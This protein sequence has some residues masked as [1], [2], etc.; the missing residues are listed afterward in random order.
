M[1][2]EDNL[3]QQ[4]IK[5]VC[6]NLAEFL[7]GKN[8]AYGNSALEPMRVFSSA[9]TQEQLF[10]RIDD[11]LSRIMRGKEYPGDDTI[12]DLLGYLVLYKVYLRMANGNQESSGEESAREESG[13]EATQESRREENN[14]QESF[15]DYQ[16]EAFG[17][18][19][20]TRG[21]IGII[22]NDGHEYSAGGTA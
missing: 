18:P 13:S 3:T 6:D 9:S 16:G 15:F 11:K 20:T 1:I 7:I 4:I 22:L 2:N 8:R 14:G 5:E 21:I 19:S 10:V 17:V 12:D